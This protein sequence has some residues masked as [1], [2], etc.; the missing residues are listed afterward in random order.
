M[1]T[2]LGTNRPVSAG[3]K[4][5]QKAS[6]VKLDISLLYESVIDLA[7]EGLLTANTINQAAGILLNDLGLPDYFFETITKASLKNILSSIAKGIKIT[8]DKVALHSWV[9]GMDFD[10][11]TP[12]S[13]FQ[14]VRIATKETSDSMEELL[15]DELIGRRRDY[16][17]PESGYYTHIFWPETVGDFRKEQFKDSRFLFNI[18]DD[19]TSTPWLTRKWYE[20]FLDK[21]STSVIPQV[22]VFNLSDIG[23]TRIMFNS[24][25]ERPQINVLRKLFSDHGLT[26]TRAYWEPY[27]TETNVVSSICSVYIKEQMSREKEA[28]I[29]DNFRAFLSFS[30]SDVTQL[31]VDNHLN[32]K[33]MLFA[34]NAAD[35]VRM[36][37]YKER[38]IRSDR[39]IMALL[40]DIDCQ[41]AFSERIHESNKF[42]YVERIIMDVVLANPDL[43]KFLYQLFE[44]KFA[45]SFSKD[46]DLN[47]LTAK[48]HILESRFMD[49]PIGYDIFKFMFKFIPDVYKTNFYKPEKRSFSFRMDNRILDSMVFKQPVFGI[50]FVNGHY[51]RGTHLRADD[52]AR[53]G[54]R[55]IRVTPSNHSKELNNAVLLNYALGPKAQRL[56]HKDIGESGSTGC[57]GTK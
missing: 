44:E 40:T 29:T 47:R 6:D 46:L 37:I 28:L 52:I 30:V 53:G 32:F 20:K 48:E 18:D 45:P 13:L 16:Y 33:K 54:L 14:R 3:L 51:A 23:E 15:G 12:E 5:I 38:G 10:N 4:I 41:E 7:S 17:N 34:G 1:N 22:E 2:P 9:A 50:F 35:F 39:D 57:Y 55:L 19:F 36:F 24:D 31:Y 27:Y 49:Y 8:G 11:L 43:I 42:T 56:K 21:V 26:I 25:F